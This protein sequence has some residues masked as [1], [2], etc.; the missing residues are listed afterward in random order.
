MPPAKV[1]WDDAS[2]KQL[3][4]AFIHLAAPANP[5]WDKV[6]ALL[7]NGCTG[8][9]ARQQVMIMRNKAK[10]EFGETGDVGEGGGSGEHKPKAG[11]KAGNGCAKKANGEG[12]VKSG[13]KRKASMMTEAAAEEVDEEES[14]KRVKEEEDQI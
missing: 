14:N 4:L 12:T 7:N 11:A 5:K 10:A 13:G 8:E 9:A 3:L 2:R 1:V 6:A